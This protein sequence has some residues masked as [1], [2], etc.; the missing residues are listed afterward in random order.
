MV[1][2]D[3]NGRTGRIILFR[4]C[5]NHDFLPVIIED[6][7][8]MEYIGDYAAYRKE[9]KTESLVNLFLREQEVYKKQVLKFIEI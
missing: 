2:H 8:R 3:G 9:G 4:E 5:L 7:T 1:L 6:K